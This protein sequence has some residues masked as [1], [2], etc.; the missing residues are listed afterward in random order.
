MLKP[1]SFKGAS[2]DA[3]GINFTL[4]G[5]ENIPLIP[6]GSEK[7]ISIENVEE[8]IDAFIAKF[9]KESIKLQ[10]ESF[11]EGFNKVLQFFISFSN[12]MFEIK[13]TFNLNNL[14]C[15]EAEEIESL[16]CGSM[17]NEYWEKNELFENVVATYGYSN[18]K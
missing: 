1:F 4:P 3:L 16:Y 6:N 5:Y 11:R 10:V 17:K 15:F 8:F 12:C 7:M 9:F 18:K 13:K 14:R 2:L